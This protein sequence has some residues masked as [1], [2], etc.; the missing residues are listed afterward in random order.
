VEGKMNIYK[1]DTLYTFKISKQERKAINELRKDNINVSRFLRWK[2]RKFAKELLERR[3]QD[4]SINNECFY[5]CCR[6]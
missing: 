3:N 5:E 2:L 6:R 1:M 4:G